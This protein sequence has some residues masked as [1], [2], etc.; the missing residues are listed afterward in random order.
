MLPFDFTEM[1]CII[2]NY[3]KTFFE[4][5]PYRIKYRTLSLN[6][7]NPEVKAKILNK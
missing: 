5:I 6:Q 3:W 7:L 1:S 2:L 4:R